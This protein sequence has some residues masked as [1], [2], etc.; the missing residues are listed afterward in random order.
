MSNFTIE[1]I[2]APATLEGA[3][4]Q[5]FLAA[6][7]LENLVTEQEWGRPDF[8]SS[9]ASALEMRTSNEYREVGL[10]VGKLDGEIVAF[11]TARLP[12]TDNLDS[13]NLYLT[14]HPDHQRK[15]YGS[16]LYAAIEDYAKENS[17]RLLSGWV[18]GPPVEGAPQTLPASNGVGELPL[19]FSGVQFCVAQGFELTQVERMSLLATP[20]DKAKLAEL[21]ERA[22]AKGNAKYRIVTWEDR[23]PDELIDD[24]ALCEQ[25][26]STDAPQGDFE[27]SETVYDAERMRKGEELESKGG[28][29]SVVTAAVD[30]ETGDMAG[31]T[32]LSRNEKDTN[33]LFQDTTIVLKAHRGHALGMWMKTANLTAALNRWSDVKR[34]YTWNAQEND[35]MLGINIAMGFVPDGYEGAWQKKL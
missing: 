25:K 5:D 9:D 10:F 24:Y 4:A 14:V 32:K 1:R 28:W 34:I 30:R 3:G 12:L 7:A 6:N 13:A 11:G 8:N 33:V 21:E 31:F 18:G 17:R 15:G 16:Q 27:M 20:V 26:M 35:H 29:R 23:C 2:H 22:A 19:V